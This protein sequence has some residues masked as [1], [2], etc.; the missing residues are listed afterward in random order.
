MKPLPFSKRCGTC[1]SYERVANN[2]GCKAC[3]RRS[4]ARRRIENPGA[5]RIISQN[6]RARKLSNGGKLSQGLADK[7]L[8]IQGWKCNYCKIDLGDDFHMDHIMPL[9]LGGQN[10][11]D[12]IQ[13][14]CPYCNC[15]KGAKH[16]LTFMQENGYV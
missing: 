1:G 12:N 14:L 11:D 9:K 8:K 7:L 15:S 4:A 3:L 2:G 6:R 5:C 13:I 10:T 16:P